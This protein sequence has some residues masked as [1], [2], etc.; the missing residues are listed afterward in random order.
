MEKEIM[1]GFFCHSFS[2][3]LN[4]DSMHPSK[5]IKATFQQQSFVIH[6]WDRANLSMRSFLISPLTSGQYQ[7]HT[8]AILKGQKYKNKNQGHI[9]C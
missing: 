5:H 3:V 7:S 2:K 9:L 1:W 4:N 6:E 8:A